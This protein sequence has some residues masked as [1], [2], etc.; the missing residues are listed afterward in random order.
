[1]SANGQKH[2]VDIDELLTSMARLGD[3][4]DLELI[5][6]L[7]E[8]AEQ[9]VESA[10]ERLE[11]LERA[12]IRQKIINAYLFSTIVNQ[13]S[14]DPVRGAGKLVRQLK[15][16][17]DPTD[18]EWQEHLRELEAGVEGDGGPTKD[19]APRP[20]PS[21]EEIDARQTRKELRAEARERALRR[22]LMIRR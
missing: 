7:R 10:E 19:A 4:L 8:K 17:S 12:L 6:M 11:R 9:V 3:V 5:P 14:R 21:L 2:G 15:H 1:M 16:L 13:L 22:M 20:A 18:E